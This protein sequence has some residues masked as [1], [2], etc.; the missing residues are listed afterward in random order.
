M[1]KPSVKIYTSITE[2]EFR[3]LN[4]KSKDEGYTNI[5]AYLKDKCSHLHISSNLLKDFHKLDKK[6][7]KLDNEIIEILSQ[8]NF[9]DNSAIRIC[10]ICRS[11]CDI[12]DE[13]DTIYN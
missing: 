1:Y 7:K 5:Y 11:I 3:K 13:V 10:D 8:K 4:K 2:S 9:N 12:T 6:A